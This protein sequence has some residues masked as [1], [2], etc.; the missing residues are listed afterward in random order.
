VGKVGAHLLAVLFVLIVV[1]GIG[2]GI[3]ILLAESVWLSAFGLPIEAKGI[4]KAVLGIFCFVPAALLVGLFVPMRRGD[5]AERTAAPGRGGITGPQ[6]PTT[7]QPPRQV[8]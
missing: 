5:G 3:Y 1:F 4:P 8:S 6:G 2:F 7:S